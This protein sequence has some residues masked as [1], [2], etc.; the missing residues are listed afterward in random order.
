MAAITVERLTPASQRV[1]Q[2]I[3]GVI[4]GVGLFLIAQAAGL[5]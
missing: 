4:V 3:G 1:A 2:I 5:G